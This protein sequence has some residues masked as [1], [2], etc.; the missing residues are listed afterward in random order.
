MF[1]NSTGLFIDFVKIKQLF[2][3]VFDRIHKESIKEDNFDKI[4]SYLNIIQNLIVI[5]KEINNNIDAVKQ[6]SSKINDNLED[7]KKI[8]EEER[9]D[10]TETS[11]RPSQF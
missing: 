6:L 5:E 8:I 4:D 9:L 11:Y 10:L 2:E 7:V 1:T 3:D